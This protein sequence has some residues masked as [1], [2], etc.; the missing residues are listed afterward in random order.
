MDNNLLNLALDDMKTE[1]GET[2]L[3]PNGGGPSSLIAGAVADT[4]AETSAR[5]R[6]TAMSAMRANPEMFADYNALSV[7]T[8]IP[9]EMVARNHEEIKKWADLNDVSGLLDGTPQLADWY[10]QD[11][12]TDAIKV[13]ELREMSGLKWLGLSALQS[14]V[15]G[16]RTSRLADLR[17]KQMMGE[18]TDDDLSSLKALSEAREPR[19]YAA[20]STLQRGWVG[21]WEN[22]PNI[23]V[24][25]WGGI[26]G[27][28]M[29]GAAGGAAAGIAGQLGPQ[30]ATPEE[31]V[32]VPT[33]ALWGARVGGSYGAFEA[34]YRQ[35]AGL[36]YDEFITMKDENGETLDADVAR[37]AAMVSGSMGAGLELVGFH[38]MAKVIP[39]MEKLQGAITGDVVKQA[40]T[41]PAVRGAFKNFAMNIGSTMAT[42]TA[43]EV[44]Q[45]AITMFSGILAQEYS[46]QDF[47]PTTGAQMTERLTDAMVQTLE[48]MT[49]MGPM[50]SSTR[51]GSDIS[52]ARQAKQNQMTLDAIIDHAQ[53]SEL[54]KRLPEK[55][56]EAVKALTENGDINSVFM[57]PDAVKTFFQDPAD[58]ERF[59]NAVGIWPEFSE[60]D[61]IGR[62][63]EIPIEVYYAKIAPT[64]FGL[65]TR[66]A[67][68]FGPDD[69]SMDAADAFN[70]AW[71][72]TQAQLAEDFKASREGERAEMTAVDG[73][74][75]DLKAR[76]MDAGITPDQAEQYAQLYGTFF[77]VLGERTGNDPADLYFK[78]GLDIRRSLPGSS[79]YR[80]VDG[81]SMAL[82]MI[83]RGKIEGARKQVDKSKGQTMLGRIQQRG[84]VVDAGGE[85]AAMNAGNIIRETVTGVGDMLAD[86][87]DNQYTADDTARQLWEE[88]FFPEMQERPDLNAFYDAIADELAGT[89][90]YSVQQD[91]SQTP[92]MRRLSD[93]VSFAD[94]LDEL[95][96]DPSRMS[97]EE[98]RVELDRLT[99]E[100]ATT[101]ALYQA[102]VDAVGAEDVRTFMQDQ[103]GPEASPRGSIQFSSG[104]TVINLF[105][106]ANLS[107]L[108]H[109]TGHFFLEVFRDAAV[110]ERGRA[111]P[112][113]ASQVQKDWEATKEYLGITDEMEIG[114]DAHERFARTF[115]AYLLEGKAPSPEVAS[116]M[117]R[118]RS[119]LVFV[120]KSVANLNVPINNKI[121]GVFDRMIATDS[122]IATA[123]FAPDFQPAFKTA[124]E[125]GMTPAQ[126]ADYTETAARAVE[127]AKRT[128]NA[129]MMEDI[130]RQTSQE[131]RAARREIRDDVQAQME[132]EPIY[133]AIAYLKTGKAEGPIA[134][135]D[136]MY[137]DRDAVLAVMGEGSLYKLPRAVPPI[138]RNKGG[139]HPDV[140]AE[141]F[142]FN[143]GHDFLTRMMSAPDIKRAINEETNRRMRERFG[144]LMGDTSAR[145]REAQAAIANDDKGKLL[146]AEMGVLMKKGLVTS[147]IRREDARRIA[148]NEIRSKPVREAIRVKL[149]QNAGYKAANDAQR[150]ISA[151]KWKEAVAAKQKQ[152][153]S[154]YMAQEAL[155]VDR[156]TQSAVKYL[157]RFTGSK[158][159]K[160]VAPDYLDKIDQVLEKFDMRKSVT[161]T[162]AQRRESLK[163]WIEQ[164]E[165][166]GN[167]VTLPDHVREDAF[168]KPYKEMTVDD[169]LTVRDAVKNIEHLGR[170]K[171]ELMT[172][173]ERRRLADA[174]DEMIASV[175]ASKDRKKSPTTR[176][177][178]KMDELW[179]KAKSLEAMLVKVEQAFD[180]MDNGDVNG[181]FRRYIWQPIADAQAREEAMQ[182]EYAGKVFATFNKLDKERLAERIS[183]PG[184]DRT[185][186]RSEIMAVA[187]N[188]GNESNLDKMMRGEG[189]DKSPQILERILSH[190]NAKEAAAV[191]EIW[192]TI[193]SLWPEI[194]AVQ[195]RLTGVEPP[196]V[197]P[198]KVTIAGVD[199][200]GGYYPMIYDPKQVDIATAEGRS[201]IRAAAE[202]DRRIAADDVVQFENVYLRPET[203]HGFTKERAQQ[204]TMPLLFNLDGLGRHLNAVIHDV[205]HREAIMD[206]NKMMADPFVRGEIESRY[207]RELYM[208][209]VPWLQNIAHDAYKKDGL[210]PAEQLFRGIR[211]RATIVAMGFRIATGL[212]QL[213]GFGPSLEVLIPSGSK[214]G[215][216]TARAAKAMAGAIKD[217]TMSPL[218]TWEMI[219][220]KSPEIRNRVSSMDRDIK[221]KIRDLTG[222][223]DFVSKAQKFSM[224]HIGYMDRVVSAPTWLAA[225]RLHLKDSPTD[226]A[227][228]RAAGDKAVR[229]SQGSGGAKD[230]AAV[231]RS[232]E[233]TKLVTMFYSYFSAYYNRQ[234]NWGRDARRAIL[235]GEVREFPDLL[236]RQVAMTIGPAILGELLV[237]RGPDDDESWM[238][239]ALK[240]AIL[241]PV[242]AIPIA[243]DA[244]PVIV[245]ESFGGYSLSPAER[246][247]NDAVIKPFQLVG[248]IVADDKDVDPRRATRDMINAA[249]LWFGLPT[250]QLA[251]S[252]NNVWLGI[253]QD[254]FQLRDLVLSRP[255]KR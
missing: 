157:N 16:I 44:A 220:S 69:M 40:L 149:Y 145:I 82:E 209:L 185:F 75:E 174:R 135:M 109:E 123:S 110:N 146:E 61:A 26:K 80:E 30:V 232:N 15:G 245:G 100:D 108:I 236:A 246:T 35:Q 93:L 116:F 91:Q 4:A 9:V 165:A 33:A 178:T 172:N 206:A 131:Y 81:L 124:E 98:I 132:R 83:R 235:S 140:L 210:A 204:F 252:V 126:W 203:R 71:A 25:A 67:V 99:N 119:W 195:K 129:K 253:E 158:R 21:A 102:A 200:R 60:A 133:Q 86:N 55:A 95:G 117:N 36:A 152:L 76:A 208:Q 31:I 238:T 163:G 198:R 248:N 213:A 217:F 10:A 3:S 187:L 202:T 7:K 216:G 73:V 143:S 114:R 197:E 224:Y 180:W 125:A 164:Q 194:K 171:Q 168:R 221:D 49:V 56:Q 229:L 84:G 167:I 151:G 176:N 12:N 223:T 136:R 72:E 104:R 79:P 8:G 249:G 250:G 38:A 111:A 39:G 23:A 173:K 14:V 196:K 24:T 189:W 226:E 138:Y 74:R 215:A 161:Q 237:G 27:A 239:W 63:I 156:E 29:G 170:L 192:D 218:E 154:H 1:G 142:G 179:S 233:L 240:K 193:N 159:P 147:K 234:R 52:R 97:E 13:D 181:P 57:S 231:Q 219:Y 130:T 22:I 121:R 122:E 77:R 241:Y 42:E 115:E 169:F 66:N 153:L 183:I 11:D 150:F 214:G 211:S 32:T 37:V 51:L 103:D 247:I 53:N 182:A 177:P 243:R 127:R 88:G 141:L 144:D 58:L 207:G 222:R 70:D 87:V 212:A 201:I 139:V 137:L 18:A 225:Y 6:A 254:D 227:G 162:Q 228:A 65:A 92:E 134:D 184:L 48:T 62:D 85:L 5:N 188:T 34:T 205:T 191:Q 244:V 20:D 64:E 17:Y 251:T 175:A 54:V 107:T 242:T 118:F 128:L 155:E 59:A 186:T 120:Y 43:T 160:T 46:G 47:A 106:E 94:M 190:L 2:G 96:L 105:E 89:P 68:K 255:E 19:T 41:R 90:R 199:L 28:I 148:R 101:N 45:E 166:Q 230:L 78:Y 113:E 50:L 112:G